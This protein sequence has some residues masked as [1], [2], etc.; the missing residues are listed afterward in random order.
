M[1][2]TEIQKIALLGKIIDLMRAEGLKVESPYDAENFFQDYGEQHSYLVVTGRFK[3][4]EG[5]TE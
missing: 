4:N 5:P 1:P 2:L 3:T